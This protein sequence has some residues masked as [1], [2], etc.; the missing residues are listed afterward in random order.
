MC[1]FL[2]TLDLPW[3]FHCAGTEQPCA[4]VPS[5]WSWECL[6]SLLCWEANERFQS[7]FSSWPNAVG[8]SQ[9][10]PSHLIL[11]QRRENKREQK[12][13]QNRQMFWLH[14]KKGV[15]NEGLG[16][17][18]CISFKKERKR[19]HEIHCVKLIK[20]CAEYTVFVREMGNLS[21]SCPLLYIFFSHLI[22][23][24]PWLFFSIW[25]HSSFFRGCTK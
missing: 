9:K 7:G 18:Y 8:Y 17:C 11:G 23:L 2:R 22:S 4:R 21:I 12:P 15:L 19:F 10:N 3:Q 13:K 6:D 20:Y 25:L 1:A 24:S 14:W 16:L 5:Y